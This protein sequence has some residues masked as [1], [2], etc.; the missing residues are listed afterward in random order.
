MCGMCPACGVVR[1]AWGIWFRTVDKCFAVY[2]FEH[3]SEQAWNSAQT[4]EFPNCAHTIPVQLVAA[5]H[6]VE[7]AKERWVFER[8]SNVQRERFSGDHDPK[9]LLRLTNEANKKFG[10]AL[11]RADAVP[12]RPQDYEA[13]VGPAFKAVLLMV[14]LGLTALFDAFCL[15][16]WMQRR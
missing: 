16:R 3:P 4:A 7:S 14:L 9:E 11:R 5:R 10:A 2:S 8:Y 15:G 6:T 1:D 13:Y 12:Y